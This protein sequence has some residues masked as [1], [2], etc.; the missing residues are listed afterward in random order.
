MLGSLINYDFSNY[1][2]TRYKLIL[3]DNLAKLCDFSKNKVHERVWIFISTLTIS[4][5]QS[6]FHSCFS[7]S[8]KGSML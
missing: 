6:F 8:F 3:G 4:R 1:V 7:F 5:N 2:K